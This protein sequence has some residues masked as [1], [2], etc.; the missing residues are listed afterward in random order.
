MTTRGDADATLPTS[1]ERGIRGTAFARHPATPFPA[2]LEEM[3]AG[4]LAAAHRLVVD[5]AH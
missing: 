4:R 3:L 5:G 2:L 1:L